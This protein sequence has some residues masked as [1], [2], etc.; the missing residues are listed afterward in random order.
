MTGCSSTS[1]GWDGQVKHQSEGGVL[2][3]LAQTLLV[4]VI[5]SQRRHVLREHVV[6]CLRSYWYIHAGGFF[7]FSLKKWRVWIHVPG[8]ISKGGSSPRELLRR[9]TQPHSCRY[10][11][12]RG[13]D[14]SK[15]DCAFNLDGCIKMFIILLTDYT[16]TAVYCSYCR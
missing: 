5:Y 16:A 14:K 10:V 6:A 11:L 15:G 2:A 13:H 9:S 1:G 3:A 8:W 4:S 7:P 12:R